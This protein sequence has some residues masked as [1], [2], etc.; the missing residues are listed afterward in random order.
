[1]RESPW[2]KGVTAGRDYVRAILSYNAAFMAGERG[3]SKPERPACPYPLGG[4]KRSGSYQWTTG[5]RYG[6]DDMERRLRIEAAEARKNK[7]KESSK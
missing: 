4:S 7:N 1:M 2:H 6:V 5:F 3:Q